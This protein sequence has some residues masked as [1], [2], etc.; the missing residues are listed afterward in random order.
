M[1]IKLEKIHL[2]IGYSMDYQEVKFI[3]STIKATIE[4]LERI[5]EEQKLTISEND[6]NFYIFLIKHIIF[7]EHILNSYPGTFSLKVLTTDIYYLIVNDMKQNNRYSR[8]HERSIIENYIRLIIKNGDIY[9]N[10]IDA[11]A[12]KE[13]NTNCTQYGISEDEANTIHNA[14]KESCSYIHGGKIL[15][16]D[17]PKIFSEVFSDKIS[18]K[19]N[20]N[21]HNNR[22]IKYITYLDTA[23]IV[24]NK[25][26]VSNSFHRRKSVLDALLAKK[27]S[28]LLF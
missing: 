6:K 14:Y 10:N 5:S 18:D 12:F 9:V 24:C 8:L 3:K 25:E 15:E 17:L 2:I 1:K 28:D 23:F 4:G 20:K 16:G 27:R 21:I 13:L 11:T 26:V 19:K 22:I 7:F